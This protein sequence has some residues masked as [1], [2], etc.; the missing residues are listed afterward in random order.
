M[1][2]EL[3]KRKVLGRYE[4][5]KKATEYDEYTVLRANVQWCAAT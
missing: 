5:A 3:A 2:E 4:N 1:A